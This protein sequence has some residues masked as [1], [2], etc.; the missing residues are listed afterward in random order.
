MRK[1]VVLTFLS[2]DGVMQAPGGPDEDTSNNF[3]YGG[4]T[5]PFFDEFAGNKMNEQMS[6]PFNLF[7]VLA[8]AGRNHRPNCGRV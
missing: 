8:K 2:L 1:L 5:V 3:L 4:W 7:S 6:M